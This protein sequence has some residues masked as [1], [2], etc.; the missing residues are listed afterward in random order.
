MSVRRRTWKNG[1]GT[2][3]E[4]WLVAYRD[5]AGRRRSKSFDKKRDADAY[6]A[7]VNVDVRKG[8]HVPDSQS[9]TVVEAG[10]LWLET[11]AKLERT[12]RVQYSQHLRLH[13]GPL[14]GATKLS[15]LTV[16][17]A[18]AFE[19]KLT[20]DRSP[21]MV[22]KVMTSLGSILADAQERG[23]VAQNVVS[24]LRTHRRGRRT[25][26]GR[27]DAPLEIGVD[28]PTPGEISTLIAALAKLALH[29]RAL[30]LTAIFTGLRASELRG[31]PWRNIDLKKAELHVRRRVDRYG[32]IGAVKTKGSRRTVPLP[33]M[34]VNVLREWK[35]ACP[36]TELDLVFPSGR[37]GVRKL[38]GIIES[39][40]IPAWVA[41]RVVTKTGAAKYT[42][43]HA[44]R[45]FYASWCINRKVDGGLELP[46]KLVQRR[47]GH[48]SITI[49]M[50]TY[51]HLFP[52]GD[53]G[54]ELAAAE[55]ALWR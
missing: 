13:I 9:V 12:T 22:S 48:A 35:L 4:T 51:G 16:P 26:Q 5:P 55:K 7:T 29:I 46:P 17:M 1:D 2:Q 47:M 31:L 10:E 41:A 42:G 6:H 23:L 28:I 49:T 45:H 40:L 14:I 38:S 43:M 25:D 18:R 3:G 21:A 39:D 30:L 15:Q 34:L 52:T 53:D 36:Q 50:D 8:L 20:K 44:F 11:C 19:D 37:G 32:E 54:S 33:P 27:H 24:N